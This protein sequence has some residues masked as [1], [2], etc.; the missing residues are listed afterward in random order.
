M[1]GV[2][3]NLEPDIHTL[4]IYQGVEAFNNNDFHTALVEFD[5]ALAIRE[6]PYARWDRALALLALGRYQEGF[7][8]YGACRIIFRN[9][10]SPRG[11][12]LLKTMPPWRGENAP[13]LLLHEAGYGD[14]IQL[15]RYVPMV[16]E[17]VGLV[18]LEMPS[19][20]SCLASQLAPVIDDEIDEKQFRYA[21]T[22]FDLMEVLQVDVKTVPPPP[23]LRSEPILRS[24]WMRRIDRYGHGQRQRIG[25]AWSV[26]LGSKHEHPN[27]RREISLDKFLEL[28]PFDG[29]LYSL[30]I[31]EQEEANVRGIHTL[32]ISDFAD[33]CA[34]ISCMDRVVSVDT[35]ALH[36]AGAIGHP[37]TFALLPFAATWRWLNG[38]VWYPGMKLCQQESPGDWR[39][40]FGKI[41]G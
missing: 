31:Q 39:S 9:E 1:A 21:C 28:L 23:Y 36:I 22:L 8:D 26:K 15:M 32:G 5:Q 40:A 34:I 27:A 24:K 20:L 37:A 29:E 2:Q 14:G 17:R 6:A 38:N 10:L 19:P 3:A 13:V 4:H 33:V 35:A 18:G 30:Q 7:A 12:R 25:I 41:N 11:M 16:K